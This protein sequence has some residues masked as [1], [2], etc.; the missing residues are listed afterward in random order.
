NNLR[1]TL[2]QVNEKLA[3]YTERLKAFQDWSN[4]RSQLAIKTGL[5]QGIEKQL[6]SMPQPNEEAIKKVVA[7][8]QEGIVENNKLIRE[9]QEQLLHVK[10]HARQNV[11]GDQRS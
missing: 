10:G 5:I 8:S 2:T 3:V 11:D 1:T 9:I 6:Q 4:L 7:V